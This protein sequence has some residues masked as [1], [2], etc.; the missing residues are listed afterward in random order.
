MK[1]NDHD[2]SHLYSHRN[3]A[4]CREVKQRRNYSKP[5]PIEKQNRVTK[6]FHKTDI[7]HIIMGNHTPGILGHTVGLVARDEHLGWLVFPVM[8]IVMLLLLLT[9]LGITS[10]RN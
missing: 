5:V 1:E 8:K 3:C 10:V 6:A 2:I 4:L 7:D 9:V